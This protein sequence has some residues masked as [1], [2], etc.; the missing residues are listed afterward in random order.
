MSNR[1]LSVA[2]QSNK[3]MSDYAELARLVEDYGFDTL[4]IY[5]DLLYQPPI[6]PLAMAAQA[7]SRILLGPASLNPYTLHPVEITGQIAT[8]DLLSQGRAY[9]GISRGA[10][11]DSLRLRQMHPVSRMTEAIDIFNHLLT[12]EQDR[13]TGRHFQLEPHQKLEY[14]VQREHVPV[15]VGTWGPRMM[16]SVST[17]VDEVKIGGSANPKIV[18]LAKEWL[19]EGN[20]LAGMPDH[21]VHIVLGA[22]TVVDEDR[23]AARQLIRS[24]MALYLPVVAELDPTVDL[25]YD[26]LRQIDRL[27]KRGDQVAAGALISDEIIDRFAFAGS[28]ADVISQ[29]EEL[30]DVGVHRIEFGTPHGSTPENGLRLLGEKV[31]P[32][33]ESWR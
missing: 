12:G 15:M 25:P 7:T 16:R 14:Q 28:P 32:A 19:A 17:R 24:E 10:W 20:E 3:S 2:L 27:V 21:R 23:D 11:L 13:F 33:L 30:F 6:L 1:Q 18:P 31:L 9:L 22:V 5:S 26:L 8:L 29:C 4:S